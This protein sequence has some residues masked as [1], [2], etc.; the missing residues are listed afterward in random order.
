MNQKLFSA[1][2]DGSELQQRP[3]AVLQVPFAVV[4]SEGEVL[5]TGTCQPDLLDQQAEDDEQVVAEHPPSINHVRRGDKWTSRPEKPSDLHV[6]SSGKWSLPDRALEIQKSRAWEQVKQARDSQIFGT[7]EWSGFTFQCDEVS[8]ARLGEQ[9]AI[10]AI[11]PEYKVLW[12]L[13][14]DSQVEL[15]AEHLQDL[16][17]SLNRHTQNA[18]KVADAVRTK[19]QAAKTTKAIDAA[20]EWALGEWRQQ[21]P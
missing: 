2:A 11:D 12:V 5:R 13:A 3:D 20:L 9:F 10:A 1:L 14:D 21:E 8:R 17:M 18:R 7:M 6:W 15:L 19:I 4:N 16:Q